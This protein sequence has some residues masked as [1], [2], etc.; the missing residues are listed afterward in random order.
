MNI[1]S[2][3]KGEIVYCNIELE[4]ERTNFRFKKTFNKILTQFVFARPYD[5]ESFPDLD[6]VKYSMLINKMDRKNA[7]YVSKVKIVNLDI[8]ARTGYIAK[9]D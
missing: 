1:D 4:Y 6:V 8:L 9:F 7:Y 2:V 3:E 5:C